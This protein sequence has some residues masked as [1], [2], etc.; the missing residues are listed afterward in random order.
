V[1]SKETGVAVDFTDPSIVY[2]SE[3]GS[4][5]FHLEFF[6]TLSPTITTNHRRFSIW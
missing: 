5:P 2:D 6:F 3:I 4:F 1:Q